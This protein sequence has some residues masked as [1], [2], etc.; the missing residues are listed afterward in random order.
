MGISSVISLWF[1]F[2]RLKKH[3]RSVELIPKHI[4]FWFTIQKPSKLQVHCTYLPVLFLLILWECIGFQWGGV[5][6]ALRPGGLGIL[7]PEL[8]VSHC[9]SSFQQLADAWHFPTK[10]GE[11]GAISILGLRQKNSWLSRV[12]PSEGITYYICTSK[13]STRIDWRLGSCQLES[14]NL[15]CSKLLRQNL[16]PS[17]IGDDA[18]I[19]V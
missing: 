12:V 18:S 5:F 9:E 8:D 15:S 19:H 10:N 14:S 2:P 13:K 11:H 7:G 4:N 16:V 6:F 17:L 3:H 1:P